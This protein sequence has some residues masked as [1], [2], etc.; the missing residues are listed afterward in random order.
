MNELQILA[1]TTKLNQKKDIYDVEEGKHHGK[2]DPNTMEN[3]IALLKTNRIIEYNREKQPIELNQHSIEP[4]TSLIL[5]GWGYTSYPNIT[6][7]NDLQFITLYSISL[8]KCKKEAKPET[9]FDTQLCTFNAFGKGACKGDS[10]GPL[11]YQEKNKLVGI[12]SWGKPCALGKPD[13]FT[14]VAQYL[15]WIEQGID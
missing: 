6:I 15:D 13:I 8:E 12:V 5:S 14:D 9:V 11:I 7:P 3:D 4:G 2:W 10:G 1:G